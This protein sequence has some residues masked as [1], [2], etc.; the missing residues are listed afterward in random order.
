MRP[1]VLSP[2]RSAVPEAL[3]QTKTPAGRI[4]RT[5]D[6][7]D[8]TGVAAPSVWTRTPRSAS[9]AATAS[10]GSAS[11]SRS[12]HASTTGRSASSG[13]NRSTARRV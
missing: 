5:A 11:S 9:A 2:S 7:K 10:N 12:R 1:R 6:D 4:R 3:D 8:S 13:L